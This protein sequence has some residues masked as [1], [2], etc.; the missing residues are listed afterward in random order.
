MRNGV[1]DE[2]TTAE[3][4][5]ERSHAHARLSK[6]TSGSRPGSSRP[7]QFCFKFIDVS[8]IQFRDSFDSNNNKVNDLTVPRDS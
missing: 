2:T 6:F 7:V 3:K 5:V 1:L 4:W 8:W